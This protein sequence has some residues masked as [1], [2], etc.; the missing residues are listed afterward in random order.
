MKNIAL[1]PIRRSTATSINRVLT[2]PSSSDGEWVKTSITLRRSLRQD[3]KAYA[4]RHDT[5]I[6]QII[7]DALTDYLQANA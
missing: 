1:T 6:Q 2:K 3:L 5:T 7:D 4:G